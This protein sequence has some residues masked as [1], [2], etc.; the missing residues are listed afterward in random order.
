[1]K[2]GARPLILCFRRP[3]VANVQL[4]AHV[5]P[6]F[7]PL[8]AQQTA[9]VA[10]EQGREPSVRL[11]RLRLFGT[12]SR[13]TT[14]S[15]YPHNRILR[16]S[17]YYAG[18]TLG[19]FAGS[20]Q[21]PE[22]FMIIFG[23]PVNHGC[24]TIIRQAFSA[25]APSPPL[26]LRGCPARRNTKQPQTSLALGACPPSVRHAPRGSSRPTPRSRC[27]HAQMPVST[28]TLRLRR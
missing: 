16:K 28:E 23:P 8:G 7:L 3:R 24:G 17:L 12:H 9:A 13:S 27:S 15:S 6:L 20:K 14:A 4:C 19:N 11:A 25:C 2:K 18:T 5:G 26:S 22:R 10:H 21:Q 1:M